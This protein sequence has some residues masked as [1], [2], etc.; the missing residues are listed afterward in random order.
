MHWYPVEIYQLTP[1]GSYSMSSSY[2]AMLGDLNRLAE[3]ELVRSS[4]M[5]PKQRL[6]VWLAY[7]DKLLTKERMHR[8]QI[9]FMMMIDVCCLCDEGI[10][11]TDQHLFADSQWITTVRTA[12]ASWIGASL[13]QKT[14]KQSLNWMK[15]RHRRQF[16][17]EVVAANVWCFDELYLASQ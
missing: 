12:L 11:E 4:I 10:A 15:R 2:N 1:N 6:M 5:L 14:A 17:K 8:Q 7:Q 13:P 3:A 9:Q 16:K